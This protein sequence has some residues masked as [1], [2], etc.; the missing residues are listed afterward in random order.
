MP[1]RRMKVGES[2]LNPADTQARCDSRIFVNVI[3]VIVIEKWIAQRGSE[4]APNQQ[5]QSDANAGAN[6]L[7]AGGPLTRRLPILYPIRTYRM[8]K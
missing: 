2:P 1:V 3:V 4:D 6:E 5:D 7:V 8:S